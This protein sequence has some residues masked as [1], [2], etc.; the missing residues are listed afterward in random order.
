ML[1]HRCQ[2]AG[3][4]HSLTC[5]SHKLHILYQSALNVLKCV[6]ETKPS[7]VG[8]SLSVEPGV[9]TGSALQVLVD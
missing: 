3:L 7:R 1:P 9:Y 2:E 4:L 5:E 6:K 8:L